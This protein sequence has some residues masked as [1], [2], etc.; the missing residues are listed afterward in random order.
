MD[1]MTPLSN[2]VEVWR[3]KIVAQG[4]SGQTVRVFCKERG[5]TPS[6]FYSWK[7]KIADLKHGR[8]GIGRFVA[9]TGKNQALSGLTPVGLTRIHLPNGVKIELGGSLEFAIVGDFILRLCGVGHSILPKEE[10]HAKP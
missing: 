2:K 4:L 1:E 9:I 5:I 10:C 8:R 7:K 6:V 3:E